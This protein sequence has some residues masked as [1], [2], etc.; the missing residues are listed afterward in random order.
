MRRLSLFLSLPIILTACGQGNKKASSQETKEATVAVAPVPEAGF[1]SE[2]DN[3]SNCESA[4]YDE[5]RDV[6]YVSLQGGAEPGDGTIAKVSTEGELIDASFVKGLNDPKGV[7][8]HGD[9]LY[10]ADVTNLVEVD[11]STGEK[12]LHSGGKAEYLSDVTVTDAGE[13]YVSE[14]H[15]S[16]VYV[17]KD[18]SMV[19]WLRTP[20]LE[21]PN[22][23]LAVGDDLY[24]G[25]WGKYA[26]KNPLGA[27]QGDLLK[28][29]MATQKISHVTKGDFGHLDGVQRFGDSH[30][31][32]SNWITGDISR[33]SAT[34]GK[35]D[36]ILTVEQ[37]VGDILYLPSKK[38]LVLPVG[39][40][41]KLKFYKV[42]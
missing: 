41:N 15:Q 3:M 5:K 33:V 29:N 37:S 1:V 12:T 4:T 22:G 32:T 34:T 2:L 19:E 26:D 23:V 21:N 35:A 20:E 40:I 30:F 10:V 31:L 8:V 38:L 24:V 28:V 39:N 7:A 36:K 16:A 27:K 14:M 25:A 11:L 42:K 18:G 17:L 9:K 13:L 6:L